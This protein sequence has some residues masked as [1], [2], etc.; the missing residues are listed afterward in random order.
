[1]D[2]SEADELKNPHGHGP[3]LHSAIR[4]LSPTPPQPQPL[5]IYRAGSKTLKAA[6]EKHRVSIA[7]LAA[8]SWV[9]LGKNLG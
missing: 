6:V 8:G 7:M 9:T 5:E 4:S 3:S 1:M 2:A